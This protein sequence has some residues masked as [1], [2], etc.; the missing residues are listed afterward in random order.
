MNLPGK[1]TGDYLLMIS[2]SRLHAASTV[3]FAQK[4]SFGLF[5]GA[6]NIVV[7]WLRECVNFGVIERVILFC[8]SCGM[9]LFLSP[10]V[11]WRSPS[12]VVLD[13]HHVLSRAYEGKAVHT[14]LS[15]P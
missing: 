2:E 6:S 8:I 7:G 9:Q 12:A 13:K 10:G 4:A 5:N 3:S 11:D 1:G 15:A 14:P